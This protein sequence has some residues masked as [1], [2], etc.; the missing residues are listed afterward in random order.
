MNSLSKGKKVALGVV[1]LLI[2]AL[3]GAFFYA[4][5]NKTEF[6]AGGLSLFQ[7]VSKLLPLSPDTKKE[8]EVVDK[9]VQEMTKKDGV[10]RTYMV[11][12]QNNYELRP[13]GGF[14]GQYAV[15]KVKDGAVISQTFEDANLLDQR[16]NAKVTPPYPLTRKMQIKKWKFRDSN[17]S[18]DFPT[19]VEKAE[20]FYRMAGGHE[21]FDGVVAVNTK[22]VVSLLDTYHL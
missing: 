6:A 17:F 15:V 19:N 7:K 9:L 3:I 12:L 21:K 2:I 20:Y 5:N 18:P 16:I 14:L 13:G 1:I 11:M 8:I 22:C 10:T 4:K